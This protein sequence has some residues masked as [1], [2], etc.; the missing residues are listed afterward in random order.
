M[1]ILEVA[2]TTVRDYKKLRPIDGKTVLIGTLHYRH[3]TRIPVI[4]E[5]GLA[6]EG[7]NDFE[8]VRYTEQ[9]LKAR[10]EARSKKRAWDDAVYDEACGRGK[11]K[12]N[13]KLHKEN[14]P[15]DEADFRLAVVPPHDDPR[16]LVQWRLSNGYNLEG[17]AEI[18]VEQ[19]CG[20][21]YHE[22]DS[23]SEISD[24]GDDL[25]EYLALFQPG[26]KLRA[27]PKNKK[28]HVYFMRWMTRYGKPF[29]SVTRR[30]VEAV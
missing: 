10:K 20:S 29:L 15:L 4:G 11:A 27:F 9:E 16:V 30:T 22:T 14:F 2:G 12:F 18:L 7:A 25:V 23:G 26:E 21:R 3:R 28:G 17:T 6:F 8:V 19:P 13:P 5:G 1:K 24:Y